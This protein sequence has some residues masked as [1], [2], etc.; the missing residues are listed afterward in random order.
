MRHTQCPGTLFP[1]TFG[2]PAIGPP[3]VF[4]AFCIMVHTNFDKAR[5]WREWQ[6]ADQVNLFVVNAIRGLVGVGLV[7]RGANYP[8]D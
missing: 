4:F 6:V 5:R 7:E 8:T 3:I 1:K 2:G